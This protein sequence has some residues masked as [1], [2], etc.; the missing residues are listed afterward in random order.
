MY[1]DDWKP[2]SRD[3][4]LRGGKMYKLIR[5]M[6][7]FSIWLSLVP[8]P[9]QAA[10]LPEVSCDD[11]SGGI[12]LINEISFGGSSSGYIELFVPALIDSVSTVSSWVLFY[13]GGPSGGVEIFNSSGVILHAGGSD[14]DLQGYSGSVAAGSFI[15]V[16]ESLFG[17]NDIF[18][19]HNDDVLLATGS[20]VDS[21]V[22]DYLYYYV[23]NGNSKKYSWIV[24]GTCDSY[25]RVTGSVNDVCTQPDGADAWQTCGP[26][27]GESNDGTV[28][29]TVDHYRIEHDGHALTCQPEPVT[30]RACLNAGC[31]S[32]YTG[33]V[34]VTLNPSGWLEESP[35]SFSG[36][37]GTFRLRHTE[38]G[39]VNLGISAPSIVPEDSYQCVG[40][41]AGQECSLE[42]HETGFIF[43]VT[44]LT[45]CQ[46]SSDVTLQA[47]RM[48]DTHQACVGIES[49]AKTNRTLNFGFDYDSPESGSRSPALNGN[50]LTG[51]STPVSLEFD[52]TATASVV[53]NYRDAGKLT[54]NASYVGSGE[55]E[56]LFMQGSD[57]FVVSPSGFE[58][59]ATSDG[60]TRLDNA[61][62]NGDPHWRAGEDF[63]AEVKAVCADGTVTPN[64]AW[65]TSLTAVAPF[66]PGPGILN[67]GTVAAAS[68][69]EG[70]ANLS[71][72]QYSEVGTLTIRALAENYL[73]PGVDVSGTSPVVGRF[74]PHHFEISTNTPMFGTACSVGNFTYIGQVFDYTTQPVMTVS[75]RNKQNFTTRNYTGVWWKITDASLSGKQYSVMSGT[76]DLSLVPSPDPVIAENPGT[77]MGTLTFSSGGGMRFVRGAPEA[78]FDAEISLEI[79]VVDSDGIAHAANPARFG[80]PSLGF[81]MAFDNG[82]EMRYGRLVLENAYGSEL[83]SLPVAASIQYFDGSGFVANTDDSCTAWDTGLLTL[84]SVEESVAGAGPIRVK[85]TVDT[86]ATLS[87]ALFTNGLANLLFSAPGSGGDGWVDI[88]L[89][90]GGLGWLKFDWD[91][92]GVH[93][94]NPASRA[95]FGIFKSNPRLIYQ[96][97]SV[98]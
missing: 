64:F 66:D 40:G 41:D 13:D 39:S 50:T 89:E 54:L 73:A 25:V 70:V 34:T 22:V 32:E 2:K 61:A 37:S 16:P 86:T 57:S 14:I 36:G 87:P 12:I 4:K 69:T 55:E 29:A 42:Y 15:T 51:P 31:T 6:L 24:A 17:G 5:S 96:R 38:P 98:N 46:D 74:T 71:Q 35:Q 62:S 44:A 8:F 11:A 56:D 78:D 52:D 82:K 84:T 20:P 23:G 83:L 93:D 65:D 10:P 63:H 59:S 60:L 7:I 85:G 45:A 68:F 94:N 80:P 92:N 97:E 77:G 48:D 28:Y 43:D 58:I 90:L 1:P 21:N 95:T 19:K 49:F 18:G 76:L 3:L 33:E 47:V 27:E 72:L 30:V 88:D 75:A 9:L 91:G 67:N 81:G 26:T 79:N 53:L